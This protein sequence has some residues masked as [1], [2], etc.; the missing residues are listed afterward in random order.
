MPVLNEAPHLETAVAAVLTQ[1][2]PHPFQVCLAIGPC[3]DGTEAIA[4]A[5]E[6]REPRVTVVPNPT[7]R[8]P[9]GLNAALSAS[10]GDVVVRVD[11]HAQLSPGYIRRAVATMERT[12]A[13]NVGGVQRAEGVT[14]FERAVAAAMTSR[15]GTGGAR[16]H[17]GGHEGPVDTVYLGVFRRS[18]VESVGGFDERLTRNQDYEL[19]IRL[20]EAGGTVWFDP[21]LWVS[22]RPRGTVR[23]L[24]SQYFQYGQWKRAVLRLH[25]DSLKLRQ[26]APVIITVAVVGGCLGALWSPWLLAVPAGYFG[27]V[28]AAA[29]LEGPRQAPRVAVA[30]ATMH[31]S[32][33][34]GFL[35][36]R[37]GRML[38]AM[39][40]HG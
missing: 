1:E 8:T 34:A 26:A 27:A 40:G 12:G 25:P 21:E 13:V 17:V 32:W 24:A 14:P 10:S 23:K 3:N 19:N 30:L 4:V 16:F 28:A 18:A 15:A 6:Q 2:Y 35:L 39:P 22:Y 33:G 31:L 20:R 38:T 29:L 7:G 36:A 37:P 5:L 9:A 11:G